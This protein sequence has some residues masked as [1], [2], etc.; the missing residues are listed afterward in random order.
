[1]YFLVPKRGGATSREIAI[2]KENTVNVF[3]KYCHSKIFLKGVLQ[4]TQMMQRMMLFLNFLG[5]L[6]SLFTFYL[7]HLFHRLFFHF[8]YY[9]TGLQLYCR[10]LSIL[11]KWQGIITDQKST[12][13]IRQHHF[14]FLILQNNKKTRKKKN[15]HSNNTKYEN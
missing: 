4:C 9:Y 11:V 6:I 3:A 13:T 15:S 8:R 14:V 1:M 12:N 7:Q 2:S 5:L 10:Q